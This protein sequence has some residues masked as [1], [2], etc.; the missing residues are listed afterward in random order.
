M[1]SILKNSPVVASQKWNFFPSIVILLKTIVK[2]TSSALSGLTPFNLTW[3]LGKLEGGEVWHF[4]ERARKKEKILQARS[5]FKETVHQ[6][7]V[8]LKVKRKWR[9][10][11]Y[12]TV[13]KIFI[14]I[15]FYQ[16]CMHLIKNCNIITT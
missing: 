2:N 8:I 4:D 5:K 15:L 13:S 6:K 1:A 11:E 14:L 10:N 9:K 7:N 16:G 3:A 12:T